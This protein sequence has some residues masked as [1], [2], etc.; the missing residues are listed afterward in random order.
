MHGQ[1]FSLCSQP[2]LTASLLLL[3]PCCPHS[4]ARTRSHTT[5]LSS[6]EPVS[7][8]FGLRCLAGQR[9]QLCLLPTDYRCQAPF[10]LPRLREM[11][12]LERRER[13]RAPADKSARQKGLVSIDRSMVAALLSTTPRLKHKSST[14]DLA[15]QHCRSSC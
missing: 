15:P 9:C 10:L 1:G 12:V 14:S 5:C 8:K 2:S 4:V 13:S 6:P 3:G 11:P 7:T